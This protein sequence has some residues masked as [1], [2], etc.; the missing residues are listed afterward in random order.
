ML[1]GTLQA[2][3]IPIANSSQVQGRINDLFAQP[4]GISE[5]RSIRAGTTG[6]NNEF[7]GFMVFDTS[8]FVG[9]VGSATLTY[10]VGALVG[11]AG[12]YEVYGVSVDAGF[13]GAIDSLAERQVLFQSPG[14]SFATLLSTEAPATGVI[15][16]D[17]SSFI[18]AE[19]GNSNNVVAFVI[20]EVAPSFDGVLDL[21]QIVDVNDAGTAP[22]LELLV[23]EP[24]SM[25]LLVLGGLG[26]L[27]CLRRRRG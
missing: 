15:N 13:D 9:T 11:T 27:A 26:G 22:Q 20:A 12:S 6:G 19:R 1:A 4:G 21:I 14:G 8:S 24:G 3:I 25:A 10:E 17:A 16:I 23:P 18:S 2:A 5:G 7:R